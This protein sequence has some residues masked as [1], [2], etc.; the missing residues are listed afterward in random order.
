MYKTRQFEVKE[1]LVRRYEGLYDAMETW[2]I[3]EGDHLRWFTVEVG[4]R[5]GCHIVNIV[6]QHL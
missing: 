2:M 5:H 4:L 6:V 3:L 1:K